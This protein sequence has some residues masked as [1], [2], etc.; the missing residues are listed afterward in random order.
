ML[1]SVLYFVFT[2][3][4]KRLVSWTNSMVGCMRIRLEK[5]FR[6]LTTLLS[7][8]L[9]P[10]RHCCGVHRALCTAVETSF[11]DVERKGFSKLTDLSLNSDI[12][13]SWLPDLEKLASLVYVLTS[14]LTWKKKKKFIGCREIMWLYIL[15]KKALNMFYFFLI[16]NLLLLFK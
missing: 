7:P 9:T 15:R 6:L 4:Q 12:L 10:K 5:Y 2:V 16:M 14:Q 3:I 11:L 8:T 1:R 13:A